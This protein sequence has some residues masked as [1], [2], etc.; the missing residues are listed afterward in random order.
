MNLSFQHSQYRSVKALLLTGVIALGLLC[1]TPLV[2]AHEVYVLNPDEIAES[3]HTP[4]FDMLDVVVSHLGEF[5]FWAFISILTAVSV[6]FISILRFLERWLDPPLLRLRQYATIVARITIG[7]SMLACAYYQASYGPELP[8]VS[9]YGH[10]T[11]LATVALVLIGLLLCM[12]LYTRLVAAVGLVLF[13]S[14]IFVHGWYMLMYLGYAGEFIA[15]IL[16][17]SH[18]PSLDTHFKL[19]RMP[20]LRGLAQRIYVYLA[21]RSMLIVR[22][23]LG[24]AIIS[25]SLYAKVWHNNLALMTVEKYHLDTMLGFEPHFLVLGASILEVVLGLFVCLGIEIRFSALFFL[26]WLVQSLVF[27]GES[28]WP[29]IMLFGIPVALFMYGYDQYTIEGYFF[30]KQQYEPVL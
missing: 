9:T 21:P 22:I 30:R 26:F 4:R 19:A 25:A 27:F 17:G 14:T 1:I 20:K 8:L 2:S 15:L 5:T 28:V 13:I 3:I 6:F 23:S 10:F 7:L 29:H 16:L 18:H 12:G 11:D 24:I